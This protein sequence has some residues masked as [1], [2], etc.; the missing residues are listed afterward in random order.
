MSS[1]TIWRSCLCELSMFD[2]YQMASSC[3]GQITSKCYIAEL[4][5]SLVDIGL[6][7][8]YGCQ[9]DEFKSFGSS[10]AGWWK[11]WPRTLIPPIFLVSCHEVAHGQLRCKYKL[12]E[13]NTPG[14]IQPAVAF[15]NSVHVTKWY[16]SVV[17]SDGVSVNERPY[18]HSG[19][20]CY[21]VVEHYIL[22]NASS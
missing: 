11:S 1:I 13:T 17:H 4:E 5:V 12:I 15:H 22:V 7:R 8:R 16:P 14:E 21:D 6:H 20:T 19:S 2:Q 18:M 9:V 10:E 3:A